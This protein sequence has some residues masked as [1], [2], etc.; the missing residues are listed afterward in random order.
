MSRGADRERR[1]L[2]NWFEPQTVYSS[3]CSV[4][5][6]LRPNARAAPPSGPSLLPRRLRARTGVAGVGKCQRALTQMQTF[7]AGGGALEVG[8]LCLVEDGSERGGALVS[9]LVAFETASE[10]WG[11]D[12]ERV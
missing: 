4:E 2:G 3:R 5:L 11:G 8:D 7:D 9:D 6:P 10:G 1:T 12:G